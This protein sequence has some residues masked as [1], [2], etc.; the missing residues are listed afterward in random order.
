MMSWVVLPL[1]FWK[2]LACP[3]LQLGP[4]QGGPEWKIE[5]KCGVWF[6]QSN[7]FSGEWGHCHARQRRRRFCRAE[8]EQP[9]GI[10][11]NDDHNFLGASSTWMLAKGHLCGCRSP[12]TLFCRTRNNKSPVS[13]R[14]TLHQS[15]LCWQVL[16]L[17]RSTSLNVRVSQ[18][19]VGPTKCTSFCLFQQFFRPCFSFLCAKTEFLF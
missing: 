7:S 16:I 10:A 17:S 11:G 15:L 5:N 6:W 12:P 4:L 9:E 3:C 13:H 8:T 1:C 14:T 2:K 19:P 18:G